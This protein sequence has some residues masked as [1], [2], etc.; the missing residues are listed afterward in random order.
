MTIGPTASCRNGLKSC[1]VC[2]FFEEEQCG[3]RAAVPMAHRQRRLAKH[4]I[5]KCGIGGAF[6]AQDTQ[7]GCAFVYP[8]L[9]L[10]LIAFREEQALAQL[11]NL[12]YGF[13]GPDTGA[14]CSILQFRTK[15]ALDVATSARARWTLWIVAQ[16]TSINL[17]P[18]YSFRFRPTSLSPRPLS[19]SCR[20]D[21]LIREQVRLRH[22]ECKPDFCP[23]LHHA[24]F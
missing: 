4:L 24:I 11:N 1:M 22:I 6:R 7:A 10:R 23:G 5:G 20:R 19:M 2:R 12:P 13:V 21:F 14:P 8:R 3:Y 18:G 16:D 15:K 9:R 17:I